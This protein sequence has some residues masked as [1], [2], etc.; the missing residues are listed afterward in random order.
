MKGDQMLVTVQ[1]KPTIAELRAKFRGEARANS[2]GARACARRASDLRE[3]I[4]VLLAVSQPS[5]GI[6]RVRRRLVQECKAAEAGAK[7]SAKR[8]AQL[9]AWLEAIRGV[10]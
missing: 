1:G 7:W 4:S 9:R 3:T 6:V 5:P 10:K 2:A 8:E